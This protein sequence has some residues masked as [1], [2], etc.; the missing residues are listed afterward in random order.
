MPSDK[1]GNGDFNS[2]AL[3]QQCRA[4][5]DRTSRAV[6]GKI[7]R[8]YS[9]VCYTANCTINGDDKAFQSR[10]LTIPFKELKFEGK[11]ESRRIWVDDHQP[12]PHHRRA[13]AT[14]PRETLGDVTPKSGGHYEVQMIELSDDPDA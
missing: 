14:G 1:T 2:K 5:Y 13:T 7:R 12:G 10:L 9:A 6:T 11:F 8:P 4:F 3:Q